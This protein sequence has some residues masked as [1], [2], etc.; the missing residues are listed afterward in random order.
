VN[1]PVRVSLDVVSRRHRGIIPISGVHPP[2]QVVAVRQGKKRKAAMPGARSE[3]PAYANEIGGKLWPPDR[4]E[5][6]L[7]AEVYPTHH[8]F[9]I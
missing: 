6:E 7:N 8:D 2:A 4:T 5:R 1:R 3:A 9:N